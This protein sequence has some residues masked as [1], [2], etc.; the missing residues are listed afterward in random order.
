MV[1]LDFYHIS[2]CLEVVGQ[3][4]AIYGNAIIA[5]THVFVNLNFLTKHKRIIKWMSPSN[6]AP[7]SNLKPISHY[8]DANF[9]F[10]SKCPCICDLTL[11]LTYA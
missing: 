10:W 6:S 8:E 4:L 3:M 9:D 7:K 1:I 11:A 5:M 2:K